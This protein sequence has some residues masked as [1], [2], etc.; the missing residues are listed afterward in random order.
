MGLVESRPVRF[1]GGQPEGCAP[2]ARAFGAGTSVIEPVRR[3]DTIVKSLA[4]G[5]PADGPY[6]LELARESGGSLESVPDSATAAAIRLVAETEGIYTETAGGV[7]IA[8]LQQA[9]ARGVVRPTDEVVV[10]LTG[11]G[12]K[13]PDARSFGQ[14]DGASRPADGRTDPPRRARAGGARSHPR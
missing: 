1:I 12:L 11:N 4:I 5:D 7:T 10:L 14:P 9:I 2:I 6:A 8:A 13:T 3:P